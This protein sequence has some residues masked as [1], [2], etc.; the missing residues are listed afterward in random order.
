MIRRIFAIP[1]VA[2]WMLWQILVAAWAVVRA[3]L[4]PRPLGPPV[5]LRYPLR[6]TSDLQATTLSWAIT[7]TPGTLVVAMGDE[8]LY[9]HCVLGG[10]HEELRAEFAE[11]E[12]R[13]MR[14][15]PNDERKGAGR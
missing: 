5:L 13:I 3:T 2:V 4:S 11:M 6:G 12:R 10:E 7:V 15:L 9:V 1:G 14:V 8:E